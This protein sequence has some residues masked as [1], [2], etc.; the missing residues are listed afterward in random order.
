MSELLNRL[1]KVGSIKNACVLSESDFFN[2]RDSITTEIPIINIA[3]SGHLNGGLVPGMTVFGGQSKSFKTLLGLYCLRAYFNKYPDA[4]CLFYDSEFGTP[5]SYLK[6]YGIDTDRII[7]IPIAHIEELKF[8][9]VK[10]LD[11]IKRG[12]HVF[13]FLDS[14]G[15]LPS[16]KE[17]DDAENEKLVADMQRSKAI[18]SL[19]RIVLPHLSMKDLPFV[20][21]NHVYQTLEMYAQTVN[22][23]G[24]AV[25]LL[26]NQ[27]FFI[28]RSQVKDE[29][30]KQVIGS[31]FTILIDK[32]RYV[33]QG[34]RF[35]FGVDFNEGINKWSGLLDLAVEAGYVIKHPAG[36]YSRVDMNTGE[37]LEPKM[38]ERDTENKAFWAPILE[39]PKF[40]EFIGE[41]YAIGQGQMILDEEIDTA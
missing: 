10:R 30:T 26:P 38:R 17:I 4:V 21:I 11:A 16:K 33:K 25:T 22:S 6:T 40:D 37:V 29:K 28:S 41:K 31:E 20:I 15:A 13:L 12:D 3:F 18:R 14:L 24:T 5:P 19:L 2:I 36:W 7:H 8:D 9:I 32:S 39:D 23:G 27:V 35:R 1:T 34:S